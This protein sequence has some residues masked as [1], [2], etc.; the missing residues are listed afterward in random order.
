MNV[1]SYHTNNLIHTWNR[2][3]ASHATIEFL[4]SMSAHPFSS[5]YERLINSYSRLL[6]TVDSLLFDTVP[7]SSQTSSTCPQKIF[8][9]K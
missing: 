1:V 8:P 4:R 5:H 6:G 2:W 9:V 7:P 3:L